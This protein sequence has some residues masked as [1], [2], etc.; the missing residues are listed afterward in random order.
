V[1][2][3]GTKYELI[4][5]INYETKISKPRFSLKEAADLYRTEYDFTKPMPA[6][7]FREKIRDEAKAERI[8]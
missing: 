8:S 3:E 4:R 6:D 1:P 7:E 5:S 2:L